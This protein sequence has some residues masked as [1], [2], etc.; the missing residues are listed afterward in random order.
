MDC[1][2]ALGPVQMRTAS[3]RLE[4]AMRIQIQTA[5]HLGFTIFFLIM[6]G[7][8][9]LAADVKL[10]WDPNSETDLAGYKV[11]YGTA[12]RVYG[13]SIPLGKVTTYTVAGLTPGTY[14]FAVTAFNSSGL[15][16]GYSNEVFTTIGTGDA[17]PPAVVI[18]S[19][20]SGA[21]YNTTSSPLSIAG[22][23]SDNIGV[24]Q[25][26]W[27]NSRGG[28]GTASGT[29]SWSVS[30]IALQSGSSV[31][32]V[33]ARD[34]AGNTG[35]ATLIVVYT[36]PDTKA[37]AVV[38]TAPT[39]NATYSTTSTP[40]SIAGTA[41]DDVGTTQVTWT[42]NRGGNGNASGTATWWASGIALQSGSNVITVTARD[43]AGNTGSATLTVTYTAPETTPP[44]IAI[45]SPTSS[46]TYTTTSSPLSIGGTASDN[47]GVIQVTWTNNRG[48]SGTAGGTTSWSVAGIALQSGSNV[49]TVTAA[50]AS[51][52][53]GTATLTVTYTPVDTAAPT[54]A[55]TSPTSGATYNTPSTPLSIAGTASDDIGVT[56]VTWA[57]NRGGSSTAIGTTSWSAG[58]IALQS[59]SNVIT[60]TA[61]DAAGKT[62]TAQLTVSY[63]A[64]D[65]AP[66][67]ISGVKSIRV[68]STTA[69]I[70]WATDE[71]ATSWVDYG[72]SVSYGIGT[73]PGTNL[74]TSHS[75]NLS[76][77]TTGTLYHYRVKSTDGAGNT[78]LSMDYTFTLSDGPSSVRTLSYPRLYTAGQ[79][80]PGASQS[81]YMGVALTN[82]NTTTATLLFTAF[83]SYGNQ[84]SGAGI[85]NPVARTLSPG[86]QLP[87]VD[88]ELFGAAPSYQSASGWIR[89][90]SDIDGVVGLYL[91][92]DSELTR[93]DGASLSS[94]PLTHLILPEVQG[95]GFTKINIVS[96]NDQ[97][98]TV[99]CDLVESD[100]AVRASTTRSIAGKGSVA[101][102]A[103]GDLFSGV[104]AVSSD[105]IRVASAL[106]LSA[107]EML[108]RPGQDFAALSGLDGDNGASVLYS[109]QYAVGGPWHSELTLINLDPVPGTVSLSLFGEDGS[110][111]GTTRTL[112]IDARGKIHIDDQSFFNAA[113]SEILQ[114]F[115]QIVGNGVRLT[116]GIIF[117]DVRAQTFTAGLPFVSAL[118][119]SILFGHVA[120]NDLY[121]TGIA[122]VNPNA[123]EVSASIDLYGADGRLQTSKPVT[124][125]ARQR[126]SGLLTEFFPELIGQDRTSGYVRVTA[127]GGVAGF[128]LFGTNN[129]SVLSAIPAQTVP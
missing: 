23:A 44:T 117:G 116:G 67:V 109:P 97:P 98:G 62:G 58:S 55:I 84:L 73:S 56:R 77:L 37:P 93:L 33:T 28:S 70:Y 121:Y 123:S 113:G 101:A 110:Q 103:F 10:A 5:T 11:Y 13:P 4:V 100:G 115:V 119:N 72:T 118:K 31:I 40:L 89:V 122:I 78:A 27:V 105:Y 124:I 54:V 26:T 112:N 127:G 36:P 129:L 7:S 30:G 79:Q 29:T 52:N 50:D 48:G 38:I 61:Y 107:V 45:T 128:A 86:N 34:A 49:V 95:Q 17:T 126:K 25:V 64:P 125:S 14:Y 75:I 6:T 91:M 63:T 102:D 8:L 60:V 80:A 120:S 15:E 53:R 71:P 35:T 3:A 65:T 18:T 83:D 69:W 9:V 39:S 42:N 57:N 43:A 99:T 106:P 19:P 46:A 21:T 108:G 68:N 92:F 111:I 47:V 90:D 76:G 114:G 16:S 20:T 2:F 74:A 94:T 24:T 88:T 51:G 104:S 12:S 82:T 87:I 66:P 81:E 59:G 1:L 96:I 41:S 22:T 85:A 32:T